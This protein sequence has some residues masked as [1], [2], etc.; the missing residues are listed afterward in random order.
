MI[1]TIGDKKYNIDITEEQGKFTALINGKNV[2]IA[3]DFDKFGQLSGVAIDGK[4]YQVR[5]IKGKDNYKVNVFKT[6]LSISIT[7]AKPESEQISGTHSIIRA[8]MSGLVISM[9]L[10]TGSEVEIGSQLVIL[11]AM[12]MQNEIKSPIKAKVFEVFVKVGQTVGKDDKLLTLE[13][14]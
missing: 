3:P 10:K 8:P 9:N 5:L 2:N 13:P 12:K 14:V 1:I 7:S 11:E 6:P 4:K